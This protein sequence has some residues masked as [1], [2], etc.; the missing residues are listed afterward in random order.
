MGRRGGKKV[1]NTTPDPPLF[2]TVGS[3][4]ADHVPLQSARARNAHFSG[5]RG[6]YQEVAKE[7]ETYERYYNELGATEEHERPA[8]WAAL[9]R[10]L[11]NSFRFAGS[12]AYAL[13]VQKLLRERYIPQITQM[14]AYEG[15]PV[16]PPT[17]LPWY[18]DALA[19]TMTTPKNVIRRYKPFASF[20]KFLVSETS[21][22][23]I[24]RQEAVSMIPPLLMD[25][26]PG[27]VVL[28][29]CAAP[30]SKAAQ[31]I[32]MLHAGEEARVQ[33][34]LRER[35][36]RGGDSVPEVGAEDFGVGDDAGEDE[37]VDDGRSTGL[38]V[39]NDVDY[40]RS[41]MLVHQMKR[42]NSPN[43][44]VTSHDASLFPSIKLPSKVPPTG[45]PPRNQ[46]LK[47]DRIL[48][49][50]PCSGDGTSRK[51][52]NVWKDWNPGNSLG[53]HS[54]QVRIL[55]RALQLLKVGGRVVYSTCSMNPVENEAVVASAVDRCGGPAKVRLLDCSAELPSLQRRVGMCDWKVMDKTGRMW[56]AWGDVEEHRET[57]GPD[58][59]GRLG[60]SMFPPSTAKTSSPSSNAE[61]IPLERCMRIYGHLQDTGSFFIAVLEKGSELKARP[62]TGPKTSDAKAPITA[63]VDEIVAKAED[64]SSSIDATDSIDKVDA[65]DA[66]L[67]PATG[68][69]EDASAAARQNKETAPTEIEPETKR[70]PDDEAATADAAMSTKRLKTRDEPDEPALQGEENR[71]VHWPPPPGA[72]VETEPAVPDAQKKSR[73]PYE[74]PFKYLSADHPELHKIYVFYDISPRFPRS[75]FMVRNATGDPTR[76]IYYTSSLARD[77]LTENEGKGI[78]FV[79]CGIKMF[80]KQDVQRA[81]VCQWRIQAEGLPIVDPW[82]GEGRVVT[83]WRRETLRRLLVEMFPKVSNGAWEG[84]GEIGERVRDIEMGC[85]VLRVEQSDSEDGF[86]ESMVL[87]LWRSLYSLNL[88]LPKEDRRAMLLRLFNDET[89]LKS[90]I[91]KRRSNGDAVE[92]AGD[93]EA[94]VDGEADANAAIDPG[95]EEVDPVTIT[96]GASDV[97]G[98]GPGDG[99]SHGE[100]HGEGGKAPGDAMEE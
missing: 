77:I 15:E 5:R 38:L 2:H 80:M 1:T 85:C 41:H 13:S 22:G 44:I 65:L 21:V 6:D 91:P 66:L 9:R 54:M 68:P 27:M 37:L 50:V 63:V 39:A 25:V 86:T 7:N 33:K 81:D 72:K 3:P 28:D 58:G 53:L 24:S 75:R 29:M 74:E 84:L 40:K 83:L 97:H 52:P 56:S 95:R 55:V 88:M 47:F 51:N 17:P 61:R 32:E 16:T 43:L 49:D 69:V 14:D 87:P 96:D 62:E 31:L 76:T 45:Q 35:A 23:N 8:F 94:E 10:D 11:P 46:Y 36:E 30:G 64:G 98:E 26:K 59:L 70:R 48:A 18:P 34:G 20:Q 57:Q 90:H 93:A 67:P 60:E 73:Q 82:V 89:P 99:V 4:S 12:K 42:L 19:W 92:T 79:H 100:E 78:R 71:Q